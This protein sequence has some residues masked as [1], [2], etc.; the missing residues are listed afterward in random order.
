MHKRKK[1][2]EKE[3]K[4][5][6]ELYCEKGLGSVEIASILHRTK[7]SVHLKIKKL[8][9][10]H[11]KAQTYALK[12]HL[13]KGCKNGMFGKPCW[14]KGLTKETDERIRS[15]GKKI[16]EKIKERYSK[17]IFSTKGPKNGMF[18]KSSWRKGQTKENNKK[19]ALIGKKCS[20]TKK[21]QWNELPEEKKE[22]RRRQG[23]FK[24]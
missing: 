19:V 3:V 15:S 7:T 12:S 22:K 6:K 23:L 2:T 9:I 4:Y 21:K 20:E 18:G 13:T 11:T 17:G 8:K 24:D 1:W 14:I 16:S 10:R 5:L